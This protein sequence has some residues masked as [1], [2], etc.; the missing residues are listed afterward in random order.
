MG[1]F[2]IEMKAKIN[3]KKLSKISSH[4]G[5]LKSRVSEWE[6]IGANKY[7]VQLMKVGYRIPFKIEPPSKVLRYN[8]SALNVKTSVTKELENLLRKGR[9]K[10]Q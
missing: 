5:R 1:E 4:V 2:E 6:G 3:K 9:F 10:C 8:R 7:I